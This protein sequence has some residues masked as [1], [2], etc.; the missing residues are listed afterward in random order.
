MQNN[1]LVSL[2]ILQL[3]QKE[4]ANTT[5]VCQKQASH[6]PSFL[7]YL[8]PRGIRFSTETK[9]STTLKESRYEYD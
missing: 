8:I 2:L 9:T 1:V 4:R 5:L 3:Y 6:Q 7:V